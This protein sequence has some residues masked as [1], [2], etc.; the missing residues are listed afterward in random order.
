MTDILLRKAQAG[1]A[2][3]QGDND[4]DVIGTDG[5]VIGRITTSPAGTLWM[6][7]IRLRNHEDRTPTH[8]YEA[9]PTGRYAGVRQELVQRDVTDDA[10]SPSTNKVI[11]PLS[12]AL[13]E[14]VGRRDMGWCLPH[15]TDTLCAR[16]A[17]AAHQINPV[18]AQSKIGRSAL[19]GL[20]A[21]DSDLRQGFRGVGRPQRL[22]LLRMCHMCKAFK[23]LG[24][25]C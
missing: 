16:K 10:T 22:Q 24:R 11:S 12:V 2:G 6:W 20:Y 25:Q 8:G 15:S 17:K 21:R 1:R 14:G 18:V 23:P 5:T 9:T 19:D 4:Y 13:V 7:A 3:A